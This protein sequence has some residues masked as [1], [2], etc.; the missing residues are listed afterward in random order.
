MGT[1]M[2]ELKPDTMVG[3]G[4]HRECY[5]HPSNPNRCIKVVV[6]RGE[7]ETR[8]EQ[9]YYQFLQKRQITWEM[10]PQFYGVEPT[11]MGPGAVFDLVRDADGEV[12]KTF[13]HYF[14]S[15]ELTEQNL[16]GL[17]T[18]LQALKTY[19]FSQNIIT[20]SIKPKNIIYQRL[21][22]QSGVAVIID[23]IGNSDAIPLA[24]Y[25]RAFGK[26]KMTRKWNKFIVLMQKDYPENSLLQKQ[27]VSKLFD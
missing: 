14:E 23:N 17:L 12:G 18:S 10:L 16:T 9:A 4:L 7:E 1:K 25:C 27:I 22:E 26:I 11:S 19:L 3:K 2:I 20:M 13:E 6:L 5:V 21:D 24:S 15:P 8:R